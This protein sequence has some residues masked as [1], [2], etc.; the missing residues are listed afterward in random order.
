MQIIYPSQLIS[1]QLENCY[2]SG[3]IIFL[4]DKTRRYQTVVKSVVKSRDIGIFLIL[5][6]LWYRSLDICVEKKKEKKTETK[7]ITLGQKCEKFGKQRRLV[8][9]RT[10]SWRWASRWCSAV[11]AAAPLYVCLYRDAWTLHVTL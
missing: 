7:K 11:V 10:A 1:L 8:S 6:F 2:C 3:K 5:F 4:S 9:R